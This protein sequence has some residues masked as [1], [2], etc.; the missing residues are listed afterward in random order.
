MC[1]RCSDRFIGGGELGHDENGRRVV[2]GNSRVMKLFYILNI[3]ISKS[4][5]RITGAE[6]DTFFY[7]FFHQ[8]ISKISF[9]V[10]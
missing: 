3:I 9:T 5:T 6:S 8:K 4:R 1:G 10:M 7:E 2:S